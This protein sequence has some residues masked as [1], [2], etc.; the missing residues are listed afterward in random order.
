MKD[1][2]DG[3]DKNIFMGLFDGN[4]YMILRVLR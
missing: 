2:E 4:F 1:N 3:V